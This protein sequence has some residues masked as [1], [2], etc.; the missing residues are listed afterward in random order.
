MDKKLSKSL[1]QEV[2]LESMSSPQQELSMSPVG[3]LT[4]S[5]RCAAL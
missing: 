3:P 2:A 5:A 1:D 4:D